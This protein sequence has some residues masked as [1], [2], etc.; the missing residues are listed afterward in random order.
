MPGSTKDLDVMLK[1]KTVKKGHK[2]FKRIL[3]SI[4]TG[5]QQKHQTNLMVCDNSKRYATIKKEKKPI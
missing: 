3:L 1:I 5:E 4:I 2:K